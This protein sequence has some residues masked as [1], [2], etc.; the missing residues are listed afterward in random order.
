MEDYFKY[1]LSNIPVV[2]EDD[3]LLIVDKPSGLLTIPTP[4]AEVRTLTSILNE[5]MDKRGG[6]F[7]LHP[8]HRLDRETSGLIIYAKGKSTQQ[9]MMGL[10]HQ[11]KVRKSYV[12][13]VQGNPFRD[14]GEIKNRIGGENALT[15]YKVCQRKKDFSVVEVSPLTGRTNQIRI[16]FKQIGHPVVG[17]DK[18]AFRKDFALRSKHL[19]LQSKAISFPHPVS[20]KIIS[21]DIPLSGYLCDFLR[22]HQ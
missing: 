4:K 22:K 14:E 7:K 9:K 15:G 20:A 19:C 18:F 6:G 10:F 3:W 8:C 16:H 13:F 11:Q 17:D 1:K 21:L 12:A 2:Y 5:E